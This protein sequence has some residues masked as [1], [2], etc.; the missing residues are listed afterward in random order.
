MCML[1]LCVFE[2]DIVTPDGDLCV[3]ATIWDNDMGVWEGIER[4]EIY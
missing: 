4:V 1:S 3:K 2:W